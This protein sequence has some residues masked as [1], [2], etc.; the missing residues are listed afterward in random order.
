VTIL[1]DIMF[2]FLTF[3]WYCRDGDARNFVRPRWLSVAMVSAV[4]PAI[5][6]YLWCSRPRG[7]RRRAMIRSAG[8]MA[9]LLLITAASGLLGTMLA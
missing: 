1:L 2:S 8:I 6:F 5:F 9:L 4:V 3:L 7:Q